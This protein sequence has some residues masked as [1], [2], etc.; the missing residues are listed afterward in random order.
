MVYDTQNHWVYVL[1][2]SSEILNIRKHNVTETGFGSVLRL[3]KG[4]TYSFGS[5]EEN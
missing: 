2:P 1:R 5:R 3:G 4:D